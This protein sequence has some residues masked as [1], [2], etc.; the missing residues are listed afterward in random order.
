[1]KQTTIFFCVTDTEH[2]FI[3]IHINGPIT[4]GN[5]LNVLVKFEEDLN[6]ITTQ[7]TV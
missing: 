2:T 6:S 7:P 3:R 4:T 5:D 1:V